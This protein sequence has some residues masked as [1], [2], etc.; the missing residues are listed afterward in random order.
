MCVSEVCA[1]VS[2]VCVQMQL[3]GCERVH[4]WEQGV[5]VREVCVCVCEVCI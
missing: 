1:C 5:R 3:D 2:E 4:V